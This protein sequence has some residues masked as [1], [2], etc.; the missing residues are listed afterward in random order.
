LLN[1]ATV[2]NG[3]GMRSASLHEVKRHVGHRRVLLLL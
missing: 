3:H 1:K 2:F